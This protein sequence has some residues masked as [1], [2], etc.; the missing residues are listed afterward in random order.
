[1]QVEARSEK[2]DLNLHD[3]GKP[4]PSMDG[5]GGGLTSIKYHQ[6][7]IELGYRTDRKSEILRNLL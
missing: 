4:N 3:D 2:L 6:G 5:E 1:M 7:K